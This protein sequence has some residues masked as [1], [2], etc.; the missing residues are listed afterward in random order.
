MAGTEIGKAYVQL[1]PSAKGITGDIQKELGAAGISGGNSFGASFKGVLAKLGLAA[2][3]GKVIKDAFGEGAALEQSIGGIETLF[4]ESSNRVLENAKN[5]WK[6]AG[7]S[8]NQ[9]METATSFSASLLQGLSGDT[10]KAADITDMAI[11]DMSDNANKMGTDMSSIQMAYQGFAKQNYTMLDNLKLGYGGTKTE[12]ERLLADAEKLTGKK[13]D[14]NNLSDVYQAIH[15]IQEKL[16]ITGTTAKEAS[17]TLAGSFSSMKAAYKDLLGNMLLGNDIS[18]NVKNLV[19]SVVTVA[20]NVLPAV[21]N[22]ITALPQAITG[23]LAKLAPE[24]LP[25][26]ADLVVGTAQGLADSLPAVL[27]NIN[28]IF[29]G[30]GNGLIAALPTIISGIIQTF[31]ICLPQLINAGIKLFVA[32]IQDLPTIITTIVNALP[33]IIN[34]I[35]TAFT[36]NV[37]LFINAGIQ[38]FTALVR[39]T[40]QII[41]AVV[42]AVPQIVGALISAFGSC[43]GQFINV[44]ANIIKGMAQ[45]IINGIGNL[46]DSAI[47][48]AKNVVNSVKKALGINSPSKVFTEIGAF[49]DEGLALGINKNLSIVDKAMDNMSQ[50]V[51]RNFINEVSL[52]ASPK[53]ENLESYSGDTKK[54]NAYINQIININQPVATPY[55]VGRAIRKEAN[56]LGMAGA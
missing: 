25:M 38:V 37:P 31:L 33:Q 42:K 7:M 32:L 35:I 13:Y 46:V 50:K 16:D 17:S 55:E 1:V 24:L 30:L 45:G 6:S 41:L 19:E 56:I 51:N 3:I 43:I 22:I 53:F 9:Y 28:D 10:A 2:A 12:M 36:D 26:I 39:A 54:D 21:K 40:P 14:I 11:R 5:S 29:L 34:A 47:K 20:K 15:A 23:A 4:K 27:Q 18:G 48:A 52:I 8:A 44:G 49:V